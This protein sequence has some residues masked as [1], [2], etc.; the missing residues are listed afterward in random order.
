MKAH[1]EWEG[2]A[3]AGPGKQLV[4]AYLLAKAVFIWVLWL[5]MR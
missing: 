2:V 4:I 1:D 5:V 3:M